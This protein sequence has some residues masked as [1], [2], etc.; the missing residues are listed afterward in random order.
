MRRTECLIALRMASDDTIY[1]LVEHGPWL[2]KADY[3]PESLQSEGF[4]HFSTRD[5]LEGTLARFYGHTQS[6]FLLEIA[7]D[8]LTS[9]LRYESVHGSR[10]PHLYGPLNPDAV[11][12][13]HLLQR[14]KDGNYAL[15]GTL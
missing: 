11:C 1:H 6:L 15:P 14:G 10:F 7:S 12:A 5:Q 3:A 9:A 13:I 8:Q 4:I 2:T